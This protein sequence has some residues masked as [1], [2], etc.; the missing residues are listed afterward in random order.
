MTQ[1]RAGNAK[2]RS[3]PLT[4]TCGWSQMDSGIDPEANRLFRH[5]ASA[6]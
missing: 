4:C 2:L 3:A 5:I 1:A 6:R